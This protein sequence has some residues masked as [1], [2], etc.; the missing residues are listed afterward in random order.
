MPYFGGP[1][2]LPRQR[3]ARAGT[4]QF[5]LICIAMMLSLAATGTAGGT[6]AGHAAAI[7]DVPSVAVKSNAYGETV[8]SIVDKDCTIQWIVYS[9]ELNRGVIKHQA[10]CPLPLARQLPSLT[11]IFENIL[12]TD[13]N[14][15]SFHTLFWG[16]LVPDSGPA[17]LEMPLRLAL[18]AFRSGG[19]NVTR[20][21]PETGDMNKFVKDLAN[22]EP[23][24]P[25]LTTLFERAK[26][27]ISI[28]SVEKV[29]VLAAEK[30]P[31]YNEL[32]KAGVRA[33]DKLPFDCMVWF[34]V[35]GLTTE[36][37]NVTGHS[38]RP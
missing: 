29:R 22:S 12:A 9:T 23:I 10:R 20:G 31:F 38:E 7:E 11:R 35:T 36:P 32:K 3:S 5:M 24:Y 27:R 30:L 17:S 37:G 2:Q 21:R 6:I 4:A 16:G 15:P 18:A 26:R 33:T 13:K 25:E 14:A 8:Y 34:S 19:W 28:A 1:V